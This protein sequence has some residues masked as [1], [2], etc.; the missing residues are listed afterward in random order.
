M[1]RVM[2]EYATFTKRQNVRDNVKILKASRERKPVNKKDG[3]ESCIN[4]TIAILNG[5]RQWS[6]LSKST[7]KIFFLLKILCQAKI[8]I[9]CEDKVETV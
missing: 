6:N 7:G 4:Y 1:A 3:N 9:K 2:K 5:R 8:S